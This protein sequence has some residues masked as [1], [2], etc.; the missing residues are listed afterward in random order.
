M[1]KFVRTVCSAERVVLID[2]AVGSIQR[3]ARLSVGPANRPI[4][5]IDDI[6]PENVIDYSR[7]AIR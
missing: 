4:V 5:P 7:N 6:K 2:V 3:T 1:M